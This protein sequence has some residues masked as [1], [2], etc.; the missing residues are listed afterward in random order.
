MS[1]GT[2][3]HGAALTPLA[4]ET[5]TAV[6][7]W[8]LRRRQECP[9]P[10]GGAMWAVLQC[11][12]SLVWAIRATDRWLL[13][14]DYCTALRAP[15]RETLVEARV[16]GPEAEVLVW[17]DGDEWLGRV[18]EDAPVHEEALTAMDR[19]LVFEPPVNAAKEEGPPGQWRPN[20][21]NICRP[22]EQGFVWRELPNGRRTV[23]PAGEGVLVRDYL[24][25]AD[26]TGILRVAASRFVQVLDLVNR[27][28][29]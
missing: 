24:A 18:L 10:D 5:A 13:A 27:E 15:A 8:V 26:H 23:T 1:N 20:P 22:L 7:D 21:A 11:T 14:S 29:R 25:D 4:P 3:L 6:A 2:T 9:L 28:G 16:F 19:Q 17:R 12:D